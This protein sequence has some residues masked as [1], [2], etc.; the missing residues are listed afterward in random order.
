MISFVIFRCGGEQWV[1]KN[2][3]LVVYIQGGMILVSV[4]LVHA[5]SFS[6][7]IKEG[8]PLGNQI[9]AWVILGKK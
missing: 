3:P 2:I 6:I 8:L 1:S 4:Y 5:S 9:G 7:Q